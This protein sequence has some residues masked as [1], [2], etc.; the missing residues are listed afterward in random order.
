[1]FVDGHKLMFP[2]DVSGLSNR[3][4][5]IRRGGH[6]V[7]RVC[8]R[9]VQ[10]DITQAVAW[11]RWGEEEMIVHDPRGLQGKNE[12]RRRPRLSPSE[13]APLPIARH[14]HYYKWS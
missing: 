9:I 14:A 13:R 3:G 7:V 5:D 11:W 1:M 8:L 4:I 2:A 10:Q 12:M 6:C